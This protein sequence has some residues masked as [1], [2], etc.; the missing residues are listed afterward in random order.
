[1]KATDDF[2]DMPLTSVLAKWMCAESWEDEIELSDERD[3]ARV[4]AQIDVNNQG[5]RVFL[6]ARETA[7]RFYV[8]LYA[9]FSI[10]ASREPDACIIIN[11]VNQR[12]GLGRLVWLEDGRIQFRDAI[13]VEGSQLTAE[14]IGTM[15]GASCGTYRQYADLLCAVAFTKQPAEALWKQF[16]EEEE[17][18]KQQNQDS[19]DGPAE[20]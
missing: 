17:A 1:M 3:F 13:D 15:L 12:L 10:P 5:Y 8:F 7:E 6:E 14:Q 20:L 16:I 11:R 4:I 19:E 18:R 9:P 2:T